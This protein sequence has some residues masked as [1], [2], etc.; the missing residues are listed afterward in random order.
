MLYSQINKATIEQLLR[1]STIFF[2]KQYEHNQELDYII[3][4]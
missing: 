2:Y 1:L 4:K 3:N